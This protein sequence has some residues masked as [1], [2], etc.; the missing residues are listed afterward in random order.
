MVREEDDP[1]HVPMGMAALLLQLIKVTKFKSMITM[2]G[3]QM[4]K[5]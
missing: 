4:M 2:P 5:Q 3:E 1:H